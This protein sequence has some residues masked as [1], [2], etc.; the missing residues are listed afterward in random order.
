MNF[1]NSL[2]FAKKLDKTDPLKSFR[3]KFHLPKVNG[4]TA[5]YFTGNSL[6]L[7]PKSTQA[8]LKQELSDWAAL[9][10]EGHFHAKHPWLY[11]HKFSKKTLAGLVGAK[12]LEVV[13]MNQ[14]SVNLHLMMTSFYRPT[15]TRFKILTEAGAFSSD[16]YAFES[17]LKIHNIN[18]SDGLIEIKPRSGEYSLR[19]EDILKA[20]QDHGDQLALVIFG[21][22]QYYSGQFFNIKAITEAGHRVGANVGFDL[23]HAIGNVPLSLHKHDVDF[24]VWCSYKYLNAGP[25]GIAGA[26]VHEKH[27]N[28][29]NLLRLAGWWGHHEKDRFQ[30]KK[31]F[32]PMP[33]ADGWQVSNFPVLSGAAQLASLQLFEEAGIK[34]LRKKSVLL[35][36]FLEYLLKSIEKN[37][38]YFTI[39]T[40]AQ[41]DERGCQLSIL[42]KKNGKK[43]FAS[44]TKAGVLADWREPNVIRVAPVPLYNTFEDVFQFNEIF[45]K[46]SGR[47]KR[48]DA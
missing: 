7:Q 13:A 26:F 38:E 19:T 42:M 45:T 8:F 18:P 36:G 15:P 27:A 4:K 48:S 46:A 23:A 25:G 20:I 17:Q 9:G 28:N 41:A 22:V 6:G 30:M 16:Q 39:I 14:L 29:T 34:N 44:L 1:E 2:S 12:P 5:L 33:G 21:A 40:N 35:T 24:A 37:S 11:Y 31:G 10:V 43:V 47:S 3:Q 32:I